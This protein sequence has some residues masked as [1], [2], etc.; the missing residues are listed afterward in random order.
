MENP[1]L[2]SPVFAALSSSAWQRNE[3]LPVSGNMGELLLNIIPGDFSDPRVIALLSLHLEGMHV[4]S[5]PG[6][7]FALDWSGLQTPEI[8]FYAAWADGDLLGCGA[9]KALDGASGEIKS[10][11]TA[12]PHLRK[13]VAARMLEQW[14]REHSP[15]PVPPVPPRLKRANPA[16]DSQPPLV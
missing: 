13:G 16:D 9:L 8:S 12:A 7:V 11:R 3:N 2:L 5:P 14:Y 10:M 4:N 6:S 1:P 15:P